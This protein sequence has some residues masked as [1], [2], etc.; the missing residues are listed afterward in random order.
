MTTNSK[1][2]VKGNQNVLKAR[3]SDAKFFIAEDKKKTL[4]ERLEILKKLF[5]SLMQVHCIKEL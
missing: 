3:F 5:F 1:L 2:I 4:K